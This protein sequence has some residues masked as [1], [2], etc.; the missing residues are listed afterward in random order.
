[1][2]FIAPGTTAQAAVAC[3]LAVA[4]AFLALQCQPHVDALDGRVYTIG[5]MIIFLSM[6][7]A[8]AIKAD[9]S[10][11]TDSSQK[12]FAVVLVILNV[13]MAVAAIL[14]MVLVSRRAFVA[15]KASKREDADVETNN[16]DADMQ[17]QPVALA[18]LKEVGVVEADTTQVVPTHARSDILPQHAQ[19]H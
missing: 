10:D 19:A 2:V 9:I 16:N 4:T 5:A 11:E 18:E 1:V 7:L 17:E 14:Q 3:I 12:A 15:H 8:L 6:F 13:V